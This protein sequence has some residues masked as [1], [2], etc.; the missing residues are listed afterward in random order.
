[1]RPVSRARFILKYALS[2]TQSPLHGCRKLLSATQR[3]LAVVHGALEYY[4]K[5]SRT[6]ARSP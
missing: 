5:A 2:G 3:L 6:G 1:M 4:S